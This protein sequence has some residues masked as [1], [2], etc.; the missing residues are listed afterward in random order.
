V[1]EPPIHY[2]LL[3]EYID[4]AILAQKDY[5]TALGIAQLL[6]TGKFDII[7]NFELDADGRP[8]PTTLSYRVD[9]LTADGW[10]TLCSVDWKQVG[11]EM[12][13]VYFELRN[14]LRQHEEG[15]HPGGPNDPHQRGR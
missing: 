14:T 3:R 1:T 15:T 6:D 9:V 7:A 2:R 10:A 4:R 12:A 13:D 11:L 5:R 8:D